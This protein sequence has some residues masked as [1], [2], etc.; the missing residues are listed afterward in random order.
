MKQYRYGTGTKRY[1]VDINVILN[2]NKFL[3]RFSYVSITCNLSGPYCTVPPF[4][5]E[6]NDILHNMYNWFVIY[7][8]YEWL[9]IDKNLP[10]THS[11]KRNKGEMVADQK[12]G[13][14]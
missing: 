8:M 14:P 10:Q 6:M 11:L 4:Q 1:F 5:N 7:N 13:F 3:V 2:L 9:H 12:T